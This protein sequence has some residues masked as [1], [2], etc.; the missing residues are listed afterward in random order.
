MSI[1]AT[2]LV[3]D[4]LVAAP[5]PLLRRLDATDVPQML[6]LVAL[7]RPGPFLPCTIELG[8]Y[9]GVFD[10]GRLVAMA[11][12]RMQLPGFTEISAVCTHPDARRRGH[13]AG[14]TTRLA[15]GILDRGDV[16]FL[17]H[18]ADNH[19]AGRVYRELGFVR[20]TGV[21]FR[22]FRAPEISVDHL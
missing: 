2:Q 22:S 6:E 7:T 19:D 15:A 9:Y 20:R 18:T 10:A 21:T 14:L 5:V 4:D 1:D 17:H 13:A 16:P 12:E 11:G 8:D 3:L